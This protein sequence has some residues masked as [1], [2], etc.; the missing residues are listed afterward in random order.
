MFKEIAPRKWE[1]ERRGIKQSLQNYFIITYTLI[2][3]NKI[4]LNLKEPN[5]VRYKTKIY[6]ICLYQNMNSGPI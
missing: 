3:K 6:H 2:N 1:N 5:T 4:T